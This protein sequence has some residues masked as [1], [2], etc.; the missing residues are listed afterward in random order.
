MSWQFTLSVSQIVA[1][2][3]NQG[4]STT[5]STFAWRF[6]TGF[7]L[8]FPALIF[9]CIWFIP[10]SPRWLVRHGKDDQAR[11]SIKRVYAHDRD[12]DPE[13]E[14]ARIR[15][16]M[17]AEAESAT[18]SSWMSLIRD[19]VERRKVIYSAGAL[20][21]Q[22]IN[23]IQWFYYFGTTFAR[24]IGLTN[25]FLM[26]LIV[27]I[28][29]LCVVGIALVVANRVPRRPLL[30]TCTLIM[31]LSI[32]IVGCMGINADS[33]FV[34]SANG[35]VMFSF[36][37]IEIVAFNFSWGP[38]GCA[39]ASEMAVGPNRN[40]IYAI[41]VACLWVNRV[42]FPILWLLTCADFRMGYGFHSAISILFGK[43][44]P[45]DRIYLYWNLS[46]LLGIRLLLRGR[47][48][49]KKHGRD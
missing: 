49:R 27:F 2:G 30:L 47:S 35:K 19:P 26:T 29:Q 34:P 37:I 41:S 9:G 44:R 33:N 1:A 43:P 8:L 18:E 21:A 22:Q 6:P 10:E 38:L 42:S 31:M 46:H 14:I 4:V 5:Y 13:P 28:I 20:I 24:S 45:K 39:I 17:E 25:P 12:Y 48:Y 16:V 15:T 40:K 7:Q 32:F 3:I 23:G 36:I 11:R